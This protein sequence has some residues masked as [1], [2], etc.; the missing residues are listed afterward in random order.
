MAEMSS[1]PPRWWAQ[2][3]IA[4]AA[5]WGCQDPQDCPPYYGQSTDIPAERFASIVAGGWHT[6]GLI[7]DGGPPELGYLPVCWG[8]DDDRQVRDA[9][10]YRF[11]ELH[12]GDDFTCGLKVDGLLFCWGRELEGQ[13]DAPTPEG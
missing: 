10:R 11:L 5:C 7:D 3:T 1:G 8:R 9:P 13:C 4:C 2:A 6:C 12:A